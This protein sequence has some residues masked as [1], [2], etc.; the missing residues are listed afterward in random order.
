MMN[1]TAVLSNDKTA[2]VIYED[3]AIVCQHI[4]FTVQNS[5]ECLWEQSVLT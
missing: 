2:E 3:A 5:P 4:Y 1:V